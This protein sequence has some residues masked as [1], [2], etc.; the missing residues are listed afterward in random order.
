MMP[1]CPKDMKGQPGFQCSCP[2]RPKSRLIVSFKRGWPGRTWSKPL[3]HSYE[4]NIYVKRFEHSNGPLSLS[5]R[6]TAFADKERQ[7]RR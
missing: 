4:L 1:G 2:D 5:R 7:C 6:K 3:K